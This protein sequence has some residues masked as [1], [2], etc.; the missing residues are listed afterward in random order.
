MDITMKRVFAVRV[1]EVID[2]LLHSD[3]A[4]SCVRK[5]AL[6]ERSGNLGVVGLSIVISLKFSGLSVQSEVWHCRAEGS[7]S[8]ALSQSIAVSRSIVH[9]TASIVDCVIP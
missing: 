6:N 3:I 9:S 5:T 8:F 1:N 2:E 7:F 4:R